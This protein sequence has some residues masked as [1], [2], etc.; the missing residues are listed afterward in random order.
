MNPSAEETGRRGR[1][2][3]VQAKKRIL[4]VDDNQSVRRL[5]AEWLKEELDLA[6]CGEAQ[7]CREA[8]ESVA[9]QEPDLAI[10]DI[11]LKGENG[12]DLIKAL[13]P[14]YPNLPFIVYSGHEDQWHREAA[15]E[16]GA[17]GYVVKTEAAGTLLSEIRRVLAT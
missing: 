17:R 9:T 15:H 2:K 16:A 1:D 3:H 12:I 5:I 6:V 8:F 11:S 13:R 4:L 7:N 10:V 14:R